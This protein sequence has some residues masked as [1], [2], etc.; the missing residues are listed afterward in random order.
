MLGLKFAAEEPT[1]SIGSA[2]GSKSTPFAEGSADSASGPA[3]S[4]VAW[5]ATTEPQVSFEGPDSAFARTRWAVSSLAR[6]VPAA[7]CLVMASFA[8]T[9]TIVH[10]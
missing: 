7:C 10:W 8:A 1:S 9:A 6:T 3:A 2:K 5:V 4:V